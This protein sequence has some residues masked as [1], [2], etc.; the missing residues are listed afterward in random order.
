MNM[1]ER[2]YEEEREDSMKMVWRG[3]WRWYEDEH[4][5]GMKMVWRWYE[6]EREDSM[7][8]MVW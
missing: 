6:E 5:D 3:A 4:E 2:W 8:K 7:K 1:V